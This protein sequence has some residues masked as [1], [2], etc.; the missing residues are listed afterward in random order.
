[1]GSQSVSLGNPNLA[2]TA[3][4]LI[5]GRSESRHLACM[6]AGAEKAIATRLKRLD[7]TGVYLND[8]SYVLGTGRNWKGPIRLFTLRI[9]KEKPDQII[10][11]CFPGKSA[12]IDDKTL[13]FTQKNYYPQDALVI[14]FYSFY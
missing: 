9:I 13:E 10:S 14:Y 7:Q 3:Y 11:L 12:R 2:P 4:N 8:V 5:E 6:D 1:M